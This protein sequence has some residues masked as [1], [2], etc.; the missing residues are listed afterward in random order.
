MIDQNKM[1]ITKIPILKYMVLLMVLVGTIFQSFISYV[2]SESDWLVIFKNILITISVQSIFCC[3]IYLIKESFNRFF[4]KNK[5][6]WIRY[7]L[8]FI[9]S[10]AICFYILVLSMFLLHRNVNS[11]SDFLGNSGFRLHLSINIVAIIFIY[12]IA[13][14]LNLYQLIVEKSAHAEQLQHRFAQ[15]RLLALKN[16]VN[17]H[18][19]FNSLSVLTSLVHVNAAASEKFII[20]LAK[21]YRYILEQKDTELVTLK[22]ELDFLD[23][24]FYLLSI[25]FENKIQLIKNIKISPE[26]WSIP[27]LTLQML[28]ENAVKHNKMSSSKPLVITLNSYTDSLQVINNINNREEEVISTGLGLENI[29]KRLVFL[30]NKEISVLKT[31]KEFSVN[32]PLIKTK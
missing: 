18:F 9:L 15:V 22:I 3:I 4:N 16:Q 14:I 1:S 26:E 25:R 8:E 27:P 31:T 24:Y 32:I 2:N 20:Q 5:S 19:L 28:V 6:S 12:A 17:P 11:F 13:S 21:A 23:A 29:K 10:C 7:P 30:T